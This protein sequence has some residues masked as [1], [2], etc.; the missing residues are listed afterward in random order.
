MPSGGLGPIYD[1]RQLASAA[2]VRRTAAGHEFVGKV[3]LLALI[4]VGFL[5]VMHFLPLLANTAAHTLVPRVPVPHATPVVP[6]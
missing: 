4:V 2:A 5:V 1:V 6:R 3:L